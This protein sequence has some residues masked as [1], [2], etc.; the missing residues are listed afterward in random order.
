MHYFWVYPNDIPWM[1]EGKIDSSVYKSPRGLSHSPGTICK[2][3]ITPR[4]FTINRWV[5]TCPQFAF[6]FKTLVIIEFYTNLDNYSQSSSL[7]F[8]NYAF[9]KIV[10]FSYFIFCYL[11]LYTSWDYLFCISRKDIFTFTNQG[12]FFAN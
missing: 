11:K 5:V 12:I 6:P 9:T 7:P 2:Y 10:Y 1:S 8:L 3:Q 4:G